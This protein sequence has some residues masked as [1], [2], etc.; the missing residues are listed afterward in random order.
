[1]KSLA[2]LL[3]TCLALPLAPSALAAQDAIGE[4]REPLFEA[5]SAALKGANEARAALLAPTAYQTGATAYRKAE[6]LLDEGGSLDLIQ[7]TLADA[8]SA[9]DEA[10]SKAR[11]AAETLAATVRARD[12]AQSA[13]AKTY[14]ADAFRAADVALFDAATAL[15]RNRTGATERSAEKALAGFRE[16]ELT[17]IKANYLNET[18][19]LLET[20]EDLRAERYAPE[21]LTLATET[22]AAAEQQLTEDRYD[23]DQPRNLAQSA[24]HAAKRAIYISKEA[25]A[26]RRKR[27][28][29]EQVLEPWEQ[30]IRR[31]ADQLDLAVYFDDGAEQPVAAIQDAVVELQTQIKFQDNLALERAE[32]LAAL[33]L[34]LEDANQKLGDKAAAAEQLNAVLAQQEAT[35]RRFAEVD[36]L[37]KVED[38]TVLRKGSTVIVRLIGLTFDSAAATLK[39]EHNL[40]LDQLLTALDLFPGAN[41]VIEGHTDAFGSDAGNLELSQRR[42]DAVKT[43]LTAT[44]RIEGERLTALGYGESQ[45]LAN[46]E[47]A[48]GRRR[49]RRID[50]VIYP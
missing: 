11:R 49:N 16:A 19:S 31:L 10:Q 28:T 22:L 21:S 39:P 26:L 25:D 47:S 40:L 23:S 27:R 3:L 41:V 34:Q 14:A 48:E 36:S 33:Q 9:F 7:R 35:R 24:K 42:A 12:D 46:N 43:Y 30:S 45:P 32:Q 38:A 2:L 5:A 29:L 4:L 13:E 20:A 17:A 6:E 15:E 37:F 50:V 18:R 44:N 8:T 1:M